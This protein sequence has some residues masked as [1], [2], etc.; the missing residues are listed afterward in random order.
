MRGLNGT[1]LGEEGWA[2]RWPPPHL[3]YGCLTKAI[4]Q[5]SRLPN[6]LALNHQV[7]GR[8]FEDSNLNH[9]QISNPKTF[10]S[11]THKITYGVHTTFKGWENKAHPLVCRLPFCSVHRFLKRDYNKFHA[12]Q[13][14]AA[15]ERAPEVYLF[16]Y[17]GWG[18]E[19]VMFPVSDAY[20]LQT[21]G[22]SSLLNSLTAEMTGMSITQ[23]GSTVYWS[24]LH[25]AISFVILLSPIFTALHMKGESFFRCSRVNRHSRHN[26]AIKTYNEQNTP[27][28][29]L[30][31]S[32]NWASPYLP[33]TGH[34]KLKR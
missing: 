23:M 33:Y 20:T 9:L 18:R 24:G 11:A 1:D 27:A 8:T 3:P 19:V 30:Q 28:L 10:L 12:W 21:F 34:R 5:A 7:E 15:E 6:L 29:H 17:W 13:L 32:P 25:L 14:A 2:P 16:M 26:G 4:R 31:R 22:D